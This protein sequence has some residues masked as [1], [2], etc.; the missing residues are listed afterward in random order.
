MEHEAVGGI[1]DSF[2][3]SLLADAKFDYKAF[4]AHPKFREAIASLAVAVKDSASLPFGLDDKVVDQLVAALKLLL[5]QV[6]DTGPVTVGATPAPMEASKRRSKEEVEAELRKVGI[7]PFTIASIIMMILQYA[8]DLI[9]MIKK[10]F[11]K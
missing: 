9:A 3:K 11:G 2:V 8:P 10:L 1:L 5:D 4:L 7:D 6:K